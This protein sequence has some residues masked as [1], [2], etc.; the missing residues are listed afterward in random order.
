MELLKSFIFEFLLGYGLQGFAIIFGVYAFNRQRIV[1]RSYI[2]G[3]LLVILVSYLVR[4]LPISFGVHTIIN[5][6][7]MFLI[8]I[9]VLKMPAY[10]TI[11][12]ALLVTVL[13]LICEMVDVAIM[14]AIFGKSRFEKMML[15]PLQKAMAGI[16]GTMFFVMIV[17]VA[18]LILSNQMKK[19]GEG[20]GNIS[21]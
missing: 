3:S 5:M 4:L 18:Y 6:L 21:T 15:V 13:L 8:C 7:I 10:K 2:I 14:I 17:I 9:I 11:Q 1:I 16:P 20:I 19:K 12:S